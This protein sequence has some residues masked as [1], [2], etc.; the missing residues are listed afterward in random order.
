[1]LTAMGSSADKL[2]GFTSAADDYIV[3]PF[4]PIE[5]VAR[6]RS[7]LERSRH[8]RDVSPLTGLPGNGQIQQ[9]LTERI[10]SGCS[11]AL[12]HVDLDNFKAFNGH[13]GFARGDEAIKLAANCCRDAVV[14]STDKRDSWATSAAMTSL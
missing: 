6:V 3:K 10:D 1:M 14:R 8:M 12:L 5:L 13:Y 7:T 2:L 4:E 11:P 9:E